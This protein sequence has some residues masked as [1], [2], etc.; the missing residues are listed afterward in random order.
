MAHL[1]HFHSRTERPAARLEVN[2]EVVSPSNRG[3]WR[4]MACLL[5]VAILLLLV[6]IEVARAGGPQYVAGVSYFNPG[7]AGQPITWPSGAIT[8]YTDMGSLSSLLAGSDADAFVADAFPRWTSISTA[9][10]RATRGGQLAED[11]SGVNVILNADRT[12]TMPADIQPSATDKPVGVVYDADGTVTDALLGTGQRRLFRQCRVWGSGRI[13]HRRPLRP[14]PRDSRWQMREDLRQPPRFEVSSGARARAG[15]R[16]G[17]VA[18][19]PERGH[20][21]S[22]PD[23]R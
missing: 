13:H 1:I 4:R 22:A 6:L 2:R 10:V 20:E 3:Q 12:I 5:G 15:L 18:V 19:E 23:S 21:F 11:V 9:A 14:C 16:P 17:M 8:Y 7:L